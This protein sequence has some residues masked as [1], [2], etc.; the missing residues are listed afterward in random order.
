MSILIIKV[1]SANQQKQIREY[2]NAHQGLLQSDVS[3]Y[4]QGRQ[5]YWIEH[6]AILNS[7]GER[8]KPAAKLERL[9]NFAQATYSQA[10]EF[11]G[12]NYKP[13]AALGLVAYGAIGIDSH[14]DDTYADYPAVSI[15][16]SSEPTLWGYKAEYPEFKYST[17]QLEEP[18]IIYEIPPGAVVL[19]NC[20]N[21][22]RVAICDDTRYSIN[23]WAIAPKCQKHFDKYLNQN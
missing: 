19:F 5:R 15:N 6:E 23:L 12:L 14:R 22:H 17:K 7:K 10:V 4:A 1:I 18:E 2:L 20:K 11:A 16:I 13:T 3:K 8:Y 9:W 21:P